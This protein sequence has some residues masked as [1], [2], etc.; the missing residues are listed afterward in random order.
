M[1]IAI[2]I[3]KSMCDNNRLHT[4]LNLM[5]KE[6]SVQESERVKKVYK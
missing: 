1:E 6:E 3:A 4:Q 5:R 2:I